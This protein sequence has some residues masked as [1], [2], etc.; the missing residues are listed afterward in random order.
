MYKY[1]FSNRISNFR[2]G[3]YYKLLDVNLDATAVQI[4]QAYRKLAL[5]VHPDKVG[6]NENANMQVNF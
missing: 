4:K 2:R 5:D 3:R 6:E 1:I